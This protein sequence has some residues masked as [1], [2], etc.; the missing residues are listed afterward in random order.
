MSTVTAYHQLGRFVVLFQHLEESVNNLLE[1]LADTDGEIVRILVNELEYSKRLKTL[2]ALFARFIDLRK[3]TDPLA[4][5]EFHKLVVEL[6][7]LG[8]RRNELV[9]SKYNPWINVHGREG[10]LRTNS[11][12]RGSS[13]E[14]EIKEE[15]LQPEA[16]DSDLLN[17]SATAQS[18]E[19]FRIKVIDWLCPDAT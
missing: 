18:L 15:E 16:F 13:G 8:E 6:G 1:L 17:L 10:L 4:K 19:A 3:N 12:L 9:H 7:K 11:K 2:D 14:R 5:T